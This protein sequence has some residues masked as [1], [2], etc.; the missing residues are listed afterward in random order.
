MKE[1]PREK[2]IREDMQEGILSKEGFFGTD[3]RSL[4]DI[5]ME[6]QAVL[7][8]SNIDQHQI[9]KALRRLMIA[10][11][12]GLGDLIEY[13]GYEVVVDEWRGKISCPFKDNH[14]T[15]KRII[16]VIRL[17]DRKEI[18]YTALSIHLIDA[19]CFFQGRDST[20]RLDPEELIEFLNPLL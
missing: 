3:S 18:R 8:V 4:Q 15:G 19:H 1:N 6:D 16:E 5:I 9:A 12:E 2:S 10:G 13:Q 14:K 20:Y 11:Q 17:S 7:K